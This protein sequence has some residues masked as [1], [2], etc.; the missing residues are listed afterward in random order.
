MWRGWGWHQWWRTGYSKT[1]HCTGDVCAHQNRRKVAGHAHENGGSST[2]LTI[3]RGQWQSYAGSAARGGRMRLFGPD[4]WPLVVEIPITGHKLDKNFKTSRISGARPHVC[5]SKVTFGHAPSRSG[6]WRVKRR[7]GPPTFQSRRYQGLETGEA[8]SSRCSQPPPASLPSPWLVQNHGEICTGRV[9][10]G[11]APLRSGLGQTRSCK[12]LASLSFTKPENV[13]T[14]KKRNFLYAES[15][16]VKF[17]VR[18]HHWLNRDADPV[19]S[20]LCADHPRC[21]GHRCHAGWGQLHLPAGQGWCSSS[22]QLLFLS[23]SPPP[24]PSTSPPLPGL[25]AA[26]ASLA[27]DGRGIDH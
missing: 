17:G 16:P 13:Q 23:A 24:F 6:E 2:A 5:T 20:S 7:R 27:E 10:H 4:S 1:S 3:M 25:S 12:K 26:A 21:C 9:S 18:P 22:P 15:S 19:A 14:E 8:K 11:G